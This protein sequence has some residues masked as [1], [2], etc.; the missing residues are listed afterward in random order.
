M[1]GGNSN[2]EVGEDRGGIVG[3]FGCGDGSFD[4]IILSYLF[5]FLSFYD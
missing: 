4:R 5:Y 3:I 1:R 2:G